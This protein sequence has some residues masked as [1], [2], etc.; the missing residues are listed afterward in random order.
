MQFRSRYDG[1]LILTKGPITTE[2]PIRRGDAVSFSA[3]T[4]QHFGEDIRD[5]VKRGMLAALDDEAR[6]FV[7]PSKS[8]APS[9]SS[10][11]SV[12]VTELASDTTPEA[13]QEKSGQEEKERKSWKKP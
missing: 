1:K 2:R 13:T 4:I 12:L 7:D 9:S 11:V 6:A 8:P 5:K 10:H 3:K